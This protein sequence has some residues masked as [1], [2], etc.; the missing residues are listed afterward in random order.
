MLKREK[1]GKASI[2]KAVWEGDGFSTLQINSLDPGFSTGTR[3]QRMPSPFTVPINPPPTN[4]E[5]PE[6]CLPRKEARTVY[7]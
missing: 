5:G 3:K 2:T 6:V 7:R 4:K 1:W